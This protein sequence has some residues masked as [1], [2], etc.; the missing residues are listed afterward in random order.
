MIAVLYKNY[1]VEFVID[2]VISIVGTTVTGKEAQAVGVTHDI[3]V[4]AGGSFSIGDTIN[5]AD[6]TDTRSQLP[7][8]TEQFDK[9]RLADLELVIADAY[10]RGVL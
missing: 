2:D 4:V 1:V 3:L 7:L 5:P 9:Q 8:T 6:F 10:E